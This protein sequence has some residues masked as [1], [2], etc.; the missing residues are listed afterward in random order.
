M[1]GPDKQTTLESQDLYLFV[2]TWTIARQ[3]PLSVGFPRQKYWSG[4]PFPSPRDLPDPGLKPTSP[5]PPAPAC[6][7]FTAGTT[8]EALLRW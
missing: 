5:A 2:T 7:F 1:K 3:A 8:S 6:R 4:L